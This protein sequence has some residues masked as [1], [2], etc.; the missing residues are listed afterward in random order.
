[1]SEVVKRRWVPAAVF[2]L[3]V[4]VVL[5][6]AASR[7]LAAASG[8]PAGG[9]AASPASAKPASAKP[10]SVKPAAEQREHFIFK[11]MA[12]T[13]PFDPALGTT[14]I[15]QGDVLNPSAT[16]VGEAGASCGVVKVEQAT[17]TSTAVCN[18]VF[19]L[20][21]GELHF[22]GMIQFFGTTADDMFDLAVVGGTGVRRTARGQAHVAVRV[23]FTYDVVV[24]LEA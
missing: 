12:L 18:M 24:K 5:S 21:R 13:L 22:S 1:M 14:F 3:V 19:H 10:A 6:V 16:K 8:T 20:P 2:A 11:Q 9:A 7:S 17:S 23:S 15:W 4:A